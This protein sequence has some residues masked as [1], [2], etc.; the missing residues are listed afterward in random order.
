MQFLAATL[1]VVGGL[2]PA[3]TTFS[4]VPDP[5]NHIIELRTRTVDTRTRNTPCNIPLSSED[6]ED[7]SQP[8]RFLVHFDHRITPYDRTLLESRDLVIEGYLRHSSFLVCGAPGEAGKLLAEGY[9]DWYGP[10]LA[11]DKIDPV[12][13]DTKG[14]QELQVMLFPGVDL[15]ETVRAL[16]ELGAEIIQASENAYNGKL[17]VVL[18]PCYIEQAAGLDGVRWIEPRCDIEWDNEKCQWVVQTWQEANRRIW[19]M[20]LTGEGVIGSTSDTGIRT[21]HEAFRDS[22]VTITDWGDYP[23]HRK[24]VAYKPAALG[25]GFGDEH[26]SGHGTHTAGTVCGDDSYWGGLSPYDGMAPKARLY[27][28]DL[29]GR[30]NI[31]VYPPDY[32]DLYALP[33]GGNAAGEAKFISNSWSVGFGY[34]SHAWESDHFVWEHPEFLIIGTAGNNDPEIGAPKTAKNILTVGATLNGAGANIPAYYSNPGPAPDG[35]IKPTIVAPGTDVYSA[36][37]G[38]PSGYRKLTGTSMACPAVAGATALITQYLREGF[39]PTG[40]PDPDRDGFDPSAALLKA[41]VVASADA[42]FPGYTVPNRKIGWGRI[43]LDSVLYFAGDTRKLY[44]LDDTTGIQTG[45]Q[46]SFQINIQTSSYPL[47]VCLVWTDPPP[48]M[49]AAKQLVNNLDLEVYTPSGTRYR[50]NNFRNSYSQP[51]GSA[52]DVNVVE[53][54]R[55]KNPATGTWVLKVQGTEIPQG[56]QPFAIVTTGDL[57]YSSIDLVADGFWVDDKNALD[58]NG[59]LDPGETVFLYPI[60]S[61][62]GSQP[63]SGVSGSLSSNNEY[64]EVL[65]GTS[66]FGTVDPGGFSQ[67]PFEVSASSEL[68]KGE[69]ISFL[70]ELWTLD[71]GYVRTIEYQ[72]IAGAGT[73]EA[74]SRPPFSLEVTHSPFADHLGIRFSLPEAGPVRIELFDEAGRRV[75]TLLD[76]PFHSAGMRTYTFST[77]DDAGRLLA[78]GVY[79]VRLTSGEKQIVC[80]GLK[81]K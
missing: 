21:D 38:G 11:T 61:N 64:I 24:I 16:E 17:V 70:L 69:E 20:G 13:L 41:M 60:V 42:H 46:V 65:S 1:L 47:R 35:R 29:G 34:N 53:V 73:N 71:G 51:A 76:K 68:S 5:A 55:I 9:I 33:Q 22:T 75:R 2:T 49:G 7:E 19:E 30:N 32:R 43:D 31:E 14:E 26:S 23:Q 28:I 63:A 80:K 58:P 59:G 3:K 25:A 18:D 6:I 48:E 15:E 37:A 4:P 12:L 62:Q 66:D 79:F 39:Y 36:S 8:I 54:V 72:L 67:S 52:D 81:V 45:V 50:G 44:L 56:P 40:A 10:Y 77:V 78:S 74:P 57:R 27:F